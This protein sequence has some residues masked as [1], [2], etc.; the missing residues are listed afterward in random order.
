[1]RVPELKLE[2]EYFLFGLFSQ[3]MGYLQPTTFPIGK[4]QIKHFIK[5]VLFY[6]HNLKGL[7]NKVAITN[8]TNG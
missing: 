8:T 2:E 3:L 4:V 5:V 6:S 1:M 7:C